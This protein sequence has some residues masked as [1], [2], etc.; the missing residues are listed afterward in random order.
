MAAFT[1]IEIIN[2][3]DEVYLIDV[4]FKS[5]MVKFVQLLDYC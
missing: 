5:E 2:G 3:Y 1:L 4:I